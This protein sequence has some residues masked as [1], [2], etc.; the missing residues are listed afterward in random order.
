[1]EESPF[2]GFIVR[3]GI[4]LSAPQ[5]LMCC[6]IPAETLEESF[7]PSHVPLAKSASRVIIVDN[8]LFLIPNNP[9]DGFSAGLNGKDNL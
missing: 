9:P 3:L 6:L 7:P 2:R 5:T 1:M 4:S 8:V